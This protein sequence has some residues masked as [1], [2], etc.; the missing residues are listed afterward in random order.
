MSNCL[1]LVDGS[2]YLY[3]AYHALPDLRNAAGEPT[4]TVYGFM[5]MLHRLE[6]DYPTA[7]AA[8]VFD[9]KGKTFRHDLYTEYKA[10][11]PPMPD[12]LTCQIAPIHELVRLHGWPLLSVEGIEADDVIGTLAMHAREQGFKVIISTGDK[13]MAQLVDDHITLV[14]TMKNETLDREG[15]IRKFGVP[16]ERIIDYLSLIGD[17]SDNIPGV[18]KVGPKTAVK[19]LAQYDSLDNIIQ[20]AGNIKGAV[21]NHLREAL[22]WLPQARTLV[23]IR[24]NSD[25]NAYVNT[26]ETSLRKKGKDIEGLKKALPISASG[27]CSKS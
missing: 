6:K 24:T 22:D 5:K 26:I 13:D 2:N 12:D 4:G 23:T 16:P 7:Y 10:N 8:C 19:W 14:D 27:I 9:A 3:R 25:L 11:R 15:V 1:L 18:S 17:N 21:G 20:N